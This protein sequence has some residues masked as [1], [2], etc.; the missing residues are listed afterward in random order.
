MDPTPFLGEIRLFATNL[1]PK[2]WAA[3]NGQLMPINQN[4]ALFSL[5]GTQYGG[6]GR[7]NFGLPDLRGRIPLHFGAGLGIGAR[8]GESAHTLTNAE[9]PQHSHP[10]RAAG[11]ATT[12]SPASA[13]W[14]DP[15]K[16]TYGDTP[17]VGMNP[18]SVRS[19]GGSQAHENRPPFLA[20]EYCIAIAGV[21]P[22]QN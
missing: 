15:G 20:L 18:A 3:C 13:L 16:P 9:M 6:D 4:Q 17:A 10:V 5:L 12:E 11:V 2:G 22:S 7:V 19:S 21:F 14:A 1:V 8:G